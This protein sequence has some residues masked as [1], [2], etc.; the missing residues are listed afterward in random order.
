MHGWLCVNTHTQMYTKHTCVSNFSAV[1]VQKLTRAK[2]RYARVNR[3][4]TRSVTH[5][6]RWAVGA[7]D[8]IN[9]RV[10]IVAL[11]R[12]RFRRNTQACTG[13]ITR[14]VRRGSL[15]VTDGARFYNRGR[16]ERAGYFLVSNVHS[17]RPPE[18]VVPN[19][20]TLGG[21]SVST[22]TIEQ[23]WNQVKCFLY[24]WHVFGLP[25]S[26]NQTQMYLNEYCYRYNMKHLYDPSLALR[27]LCRLVRYQ[28]FWH[29]NPNRRIDSL[30]RLPPAAPTHPDP[31]PHLPLIPPV[32]FLGP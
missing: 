28:R 10:Q 4:T 3:R 13:F 31:M 7:V 19:L 23:Q 1:V 26:Q 2:R 9:S 14:W 5:V 18:R 21:R 32:P 25:L 17:R 24:K 12:G 11:Q 8:K 15:V 6:E 22:Q 16:L 20:R 29:E 30:A 27:D